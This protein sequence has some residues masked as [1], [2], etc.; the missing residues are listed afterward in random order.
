MV[1]RVPDCRLRCRQ[2]CRQLATAY[3]PCSPL[4]SLPARLSDKVAESLMI[5]YA[6]YECVSE[7]G[8]R[9]PLGAS[10]L[11]FVPECHLLVSAN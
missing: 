9:R 10:R 1:L 2:H 5:L 8:D 6:S 4:P 3:W 7:R 11:Q